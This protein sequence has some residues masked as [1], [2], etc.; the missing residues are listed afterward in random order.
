MARFWLKVS[1]IEISQQ[2]TTISAVTLCSF[3]GIGWNA[4]LPLHPK[5]LYSSTSCGFQAR[6]DSLW[7]RFISCKM[8]VWLP[9]KYPYLPATTLWYRSQSLV[10]RWPMYMLHMLVI[11]FHRQQYWYVITS[12]NQWDRP[13]TCPGALYG[14][15]PVSQE[16]KTTLNTTS[17][18]TLQR[19]E[20]NY[21]GT[22]V[23]KVWVTNSENQTL[24]KY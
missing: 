13:G 9:V 24:W 19:L 11:L 20:Q 10:G 18:P 21:I 16:R 6:M 5:Y 7:G 22:S 14:A 2:A 23:C 17:I 4:A 12:N 1:C 8:V 3:T 15:A